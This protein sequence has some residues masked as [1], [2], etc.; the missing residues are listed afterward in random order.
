MIYFFFS[1]F[2]IVEV[3]KR[4]KSPIKSKA[5][6]AADSY[7]K[8]TNSKEINSQNAVNVCGAF[9]LENHNT[10]YTWAIHFSDVFT[11]AIS[12]AWD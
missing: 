2:R 8:T 11:T 9:E 10:K 12:S 1:I 4:N 3:K 6:R 5:K 7:R